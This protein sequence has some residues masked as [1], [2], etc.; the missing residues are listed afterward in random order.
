MLR[1]RYVSMLIALCALLVSVLSPTTCVAQAEDAMELNTK[2]HKREKRER[3]WG[4]YSD[5]TTRFRAT[6]LIAPG[7]LFTLGALGIG[8]NAPLS[9]INSSLRGGV[10]QINGRRPLRFDDYLQYAPVVG[11]L[12]LCLTPIKAK[13]TPG[14]RIAAAAA[15]YLSMTLL[16]NSLK[17]SVCELRPDGSRRNSF[18]SGHT[19]TAFTGAELVRTEY[20]WEAG[21]IAYAAATTVGFMRIYNNRHWCNDVLAGAAVGIISARIGYWLLPLS[22]KIFRI[23]P[24]HAVAA[25]PMFFPEQQALGLSCSVCF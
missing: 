10:A 21:L 5:S 9:K 18:P 13:H 3:W 2:C 14:E 16:T 12:T 25:A 19:A 8:D 17:Y 22:R 20:G 7:A 23:K 15:A 11:Y 4:E 6:Q 24:K 1:S